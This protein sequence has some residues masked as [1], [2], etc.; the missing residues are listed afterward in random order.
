MKLLIAFLIVLIVF[1]LVPQAADARPDNGPCYSR[2]VTTSVEGDTWRGIARIWGMKV[3]TLKR[4]N[5]HVK[6]GLWGALPAGSQIRVS[7][8]TGWGC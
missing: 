2:G 8:I 1:T 5:P 3:S 4:M 7:Q 6:A